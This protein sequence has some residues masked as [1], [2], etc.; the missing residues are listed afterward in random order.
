MSTDATSGALPPN[1]RLTRGEVLKRGALFAA[2]AFAL[3]ALS[4]CGSDDDSGA[5]TTAGPATTTANSTASTTAETSDTTG[6]GTAGSTADTTAGSTADTTAATTAGTTANTTADTT[7][8]SDGGLSADSIA[9]IQKFMGDVDP[10][11]AG[12]GETWDIGGIF[13]FSG[14]G[15]SYGEVMGNGVKLAVR[16]I[17]QLGGPKINVDFR[18]HANSDPVKTKNAFLAFEKLPAVIS[19]YEVG[20]LIVKDLIEK[21]HNLTIDPGGG[22]APPGDKLPYFWGMRANFG[23]DGFKLAGTYLAQQLKK[24]KVVLVFYNVGAVSDTYINAATLS[25]EAGGAEIVNVVK[26]QYGTTD[27]SNE[28]TAIRASGDFDAVSLGLAG[29]D[30]A[31]F[32]KQYKTSGIDKPIVTWDGM[33]APIAK[34]AGADVYEGVYLGG[35]DDFSVNSANPWAQEFIKSYKATYSDNGFPGASPDFNSA[36]Y[37]NATFLLWRLYR[38]VKAAGGDVNDGEQL[39]AALVANPKSVGVIGGDAEA[40]GIAEFDVVSHGL[41]HQPMGFYRVEDGAPVPLATSDIG[42]A[43]IKI[44]A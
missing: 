21:N 14:T 2:G 18:D 12:T 34:I 20:G 38:D 33:V 5:D 23:F 17:E 43:D 19:S 3:P 25:M 8:T 22:N 44:I 13:P 6:A 11:F 30:I 28:L 41:K 26:P 37:Y 39:Q 15:A 1:Q 40:A 32:L 9:T 27:F 36:G 31:T 35:V 24:P 29:N 10:K 7:D 16:H 42:G 4:A